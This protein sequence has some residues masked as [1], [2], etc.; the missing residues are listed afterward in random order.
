MAVIVTGASGQFGRAAAEQLLEKID[1]AELILVT[2]NPGKLADFAARGVQVRKGDFDE[3][4]GLAQAFAGGD[5]MLLIST[6][7]VGG[8]VLQHRNA[9]EAAKAAGVRHLAYTSSAGMS[10]ENPAIVV[11]DHLATEE[12]LKA[13]GMHWTF[14]RDNHYAEAVA[15]A[16]APRA[17]ATGAWIASAGEGRVGSVSR[18]DCVACAVA[19]LTQ[20]G[21]EDKA[22]DLTGPQTW[23][24]R[25]ITQ[26]LTELT[27]RPVEY[28]LVTDEGMF[29]MFDSLGIPRRPV[30]DQIVNNIPWCSEDMVTYERSVREGWFDVCTDDVRRLTGR[31][32]RSLRQVLTDHMALLTGG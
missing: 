8:R 22:Y 27:G 26:L 5:R 15:T 6:A 30:D 2:R 23:S 10:P 7:R 25:E 17:V 18:D 13:S 9:I 16:I 28:R 19:V 29:E 3:P 21:H 31:E 1:P 14:L 4:E 32:P 11:R 20:P 24:F 12:M